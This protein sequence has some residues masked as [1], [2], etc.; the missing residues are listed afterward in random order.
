MLMD[1]RVPAA[2]PLGPDEA[3]RRLAERYFRSRGPA[4]LQDFA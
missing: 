1:D 2:A 4:Q 3:L